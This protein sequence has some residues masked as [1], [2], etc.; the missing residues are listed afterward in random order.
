MVNLF[1]CWK[2]QGEGSLDDHRGEDERCFASHSASRVV[3]TPV[4]A[5]TGCISD[6]LFSLLLGSRVGT[7]GI[8]Y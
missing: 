8:I 2:P 5:Q 1:V 7:L 6:S 3:L 4:Q